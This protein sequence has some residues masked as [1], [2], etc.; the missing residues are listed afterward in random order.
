[1]CL[2]GVS[3][4]THAAHDTKNIVVGSK[5][6]NL[7]GAG[8]LNGGIGQNQLKG[9]IVNAGEVATAAWLMLF[10]PKGK[11]VQIDTGVGVAA[12]VLPRLNEV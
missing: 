10:G 8:S 6:A 2:I 1:M 9:G 11:G 12:V 4:T 7:G 5:H 3:K